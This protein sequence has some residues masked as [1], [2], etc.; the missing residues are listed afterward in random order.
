VEVAKNV[1]IGVDLGRL[2]D[3]SA[4]TVAERYQVVRD[5]GH[6]EPA[7]FTDYY[8]VLE[9]HKWPLMTP[10]SQVIRDIGSMPPA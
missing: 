1:T 8:R 5:L 4:V 7:Q 2:V 3:Q 6:T 9:L 10:Y